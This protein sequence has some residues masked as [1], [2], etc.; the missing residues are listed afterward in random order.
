MTI[1]TGAQNR[2]E[3]YKDFVLK[4]A[5]YNRINLDEHFIQFLYRKLYKTGRDIVDGGANRGLHTVEMSRLLSA[6]S[7]TVWAFEPIPAVIN[8]LKQ[9]LAA[10]GCKNVNITEAALSE[11]GGETEFH[12][13]RNLDGQS[14][15]KKRQTYSDAPDIEI[16]RVRATTL[17]AFIKSIDPYFIKLDLEGGEFPALKGGAA[18]IQRSRPVIAFENGLAYSGE[19]YR[20]TEDEFFS[21][22]K[23]I[24]Y[25]VLDFAGQI[26]E[27][28]HWR[29]G[30]LWQFLAVPQEEFPDLHPFAKHVMDEV[31]EIFERAAMS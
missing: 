18:L 4:G 28:L 1:D 25:V 27:P 17:D 10:A 19:A 11:S 2:F 24:N 13:I 30:L 9:N 23:Q 5:L 22:F 21:F 6:G 29:T 20:Y 16:I 8:L 3:K 12:Y 7:G 15:I 14:G 26:V 31:L